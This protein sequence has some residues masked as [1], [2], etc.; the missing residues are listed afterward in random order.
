MRRKRKDPLNTYTV[1]KK[2]AVSVVI[3][4]HDKLTD[5]DSVRKEKFNWV[6]GFKSFPPS[7][8][9]CFGVNSDGVDS[10]ELMVELTSCLMGRGG[11][12]KEAKAQG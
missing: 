11:G 7:W 1:H 5:T 2:A 6:H 10:R 4:Y 3:C 12:K 8:L 9:H